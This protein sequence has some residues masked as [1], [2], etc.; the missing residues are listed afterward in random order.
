MPESWCCEGSGKKIRRHHFAVIFGCESVRVAD[1][2][3]ANSKNT[4]KPMKKSLILTVGAVAWLPL[5]MVAGDDLKLE[6]CPPAVQAAI[7]ASAA[8]GTVDEIHMKTIDGR[9]EY[10]AEVEVTN[11]EDRKVHVDANGALLK[12]SEE[13]AEA[14]A[15][16]A[17]LNVAKGF[18]PQGG[19]I[20][21][22]EK[23]V[24][25]GRTT[26]SMDI[27]RPGSADLELV[28]ADNGAVISQT[29]EEKEHKKDKKK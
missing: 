6:A 26:Y 16:A 29:E 23:E 20:D 21:E 3:V 14:N 11:G 2:E 4:N 12:T 25:G 24:A 27:D 13:V 1:E 22:I 7:K 15:P 18:V 10:V 17:V 28:L 19:K 9:T 5:T 8:D